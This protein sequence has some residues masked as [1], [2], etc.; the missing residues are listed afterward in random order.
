MS[1]LNI[2]KGDWEVGEIDPTKVWSDAH[3]R[4]SC[5]AWSTNEVQKRDFYFDKSIDE[6]KANAILIADAGTTY[7]KCLKTPSQLLAI[8]E[9]LMEALKEFKEAVDSEEIIIQENYDNDGYENRG[10]RLYSK[11]SQLLTKYK[12][13]DILP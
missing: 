4:G 6:M 9:E 5:V 11:F 12:P 2:T 3:S 1:E 8:N 10:G 7:N 13:N